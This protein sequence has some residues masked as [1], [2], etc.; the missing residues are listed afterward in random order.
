VLV[1]T[2]QQDDIGQG[3]DAAHAHDLAGHVQDLEPFQQ[4]APIIA[5]AGPVGAKLLPELVLDL[6]A[7]QPEGGFEVAGRDNDRRLADDPVVPVD[8]LTELRQRLQA[9]AGASLRGLL[10]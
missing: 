2:L 7:G 4:L 6:V 8:Q 10:A 5:E 3:A 1:A 9:V